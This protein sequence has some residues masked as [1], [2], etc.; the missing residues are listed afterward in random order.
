MVQEDHNHPYF[1]SP[2]AELVRTSLAAFKERGV[3]LRA[4]AK[5]LEY[6]QAAVLSHIATG[7]VMVP[8]ERVADLA[9]VLEID[10]GKMMIAA[11]KQRFPGLTWRSMLQESPTVSPA[12]RDV[13]WRLEGAAG[14]PLSELTP[15]QISIM[16]EV[17]ATPEPSRRWLTV[18]ELPA[19]ELLRRREP[20]FRSK[21]L[22]RASLDL[23]ELG[24]D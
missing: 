1:H 10:E 4:L 16:M 13:I 7:R 11:M 2:A 18:H 3:S 15:E 19:V 8:L 22:S 17:A 14:K 20:E 23:I 12:E 9:R 6:K 21:G 5:K 24:Y